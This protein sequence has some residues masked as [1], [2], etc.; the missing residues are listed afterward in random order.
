MWGAGL[1]EGEKEEGAK[2][3]QALLEAAGEADGD[4]DGSGDEGGRKKNQFR[5]HLKANEAVS[6][7]H[8]FCVFFLLDVPHDIKQERRY[9]VRITNEILGCIDLLR[10]TILHACVHS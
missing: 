5:T 8:R 6:T 9:I 10:I 7:S 1:T 4:E 2:A 3:K